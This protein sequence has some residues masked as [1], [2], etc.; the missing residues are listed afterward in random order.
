[1]KIL[2]D[3]NLPFSLAH[4]GLQTQIEQT[5]AALERVGLSVEYLRWWD[6]RQQGDIIHFFGCAPAAVLKQAKLQRVPVVMTSLFTDT[7]NRSDLRLNIQ[8]MIIRTLL[9][10]PV[11]RGVKQQLTWSAFG[12]CPHNVV[13]LEAEARVLE[14][15]YGIRREMISVV[16]LGLSEEYLR[17]G[18]GTRNASHLICTGTITERKCSLELAQLAKAAEVPIL[19]VGKPYHPTDSYWERFQ[20]MVD[21]RLVMHRPHVASE[22]EMISLLGEA[23]GFVMMSKHENWCLSAHEAVACGLPLLVQD[24]RWSRERFGNRVNYFPHIGVSAA[25]IEMLKRFYRNAD[26]ATPPN[27][28]LH[29][30]EDT[31]RALQKV[32][33][34]LLKIA[35]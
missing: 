20:A 2:F 11:A 8:G 30:W 19:F 34:N 3:H 21:D 27:I 33:R 10:L 26:K 23:R 6:V 14:L 29:S 15:V 18:R 22:Q 32:Y 17:A 24:Q 28:Q 9:Q 35:S 31:A 1:M 4:G 5:K 13:G 7:C 25:N 16:P 12:N